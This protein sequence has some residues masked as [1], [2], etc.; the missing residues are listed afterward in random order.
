V[1]VDD[2]ELETSDIVVD[3]DF[4]DDVVTEFDEDGRRMGS[5][6]NFVRDIFFR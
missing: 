6:I 5:S 4:V 1:S 2:D 3:D